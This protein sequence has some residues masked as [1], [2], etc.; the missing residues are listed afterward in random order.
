MTKWN[1]ILETAWDKEAMKQ[2]AQGNLSG[3]QLY[4]EFVY[5]PVG[6]E[7]RNL[8]RDNGVRRARQLAKKAV[9]RRGL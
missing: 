7:V 1:V 8:L 9:N 2:F 3:R 4:N 5:T 6:G